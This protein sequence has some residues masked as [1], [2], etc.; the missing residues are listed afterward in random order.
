[1]LALIAGAALAACSYSG[2]PGDPVLRRLSYFSFLAADDIREACAQGGAERYRFVYNADYSLQVRLYEIA[3]DPGTG[4][5][6]QITR[7]LGGR[8]VGAFQFA[9]VNWLLEQ[10]S[11]RALLGMADLE[12]LRGMLS[13]SPS[14]R[15][16]TLICGRMTITGWSARV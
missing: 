11:D 16:V 7:V 5:G 8:R 6:R 15:Q 13:A 14:R 10:A 9:F 4:E 2:L 1:M 12:T 3:V